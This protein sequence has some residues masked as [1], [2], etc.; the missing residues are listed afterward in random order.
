MLERGLSPTQ[1]FR[2]S[3]QGTGTVR[4]TNANW[5]RFQTM[6]RIHTPSTSSTSPHLSNPPSIFCRG[7]AWV[8]LDRV[9]GLRVLAPTLGTSSIEPRFGEGVK[10]DPSFDNA[11]E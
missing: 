1:L 6:L 2:L 3:A 10:F 5:S 4:G 7:E 9:I 8:S 11:V